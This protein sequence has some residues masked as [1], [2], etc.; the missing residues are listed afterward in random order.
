MGD[1]VNLTE[2]TFDEEVLKSNIPVLIDFWAEWCAPCKMLGPTIEEIAAEYQ[3]RAKVAKINVDQNPGLAQRYGI[4]S[5]PAIIIF[6]NGE[7]ADQLIGVQSKETM[8]AMID[9]SLA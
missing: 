6:S 8:A 9:K 7:V 4:R 1:E 5:I 3:G 2:A